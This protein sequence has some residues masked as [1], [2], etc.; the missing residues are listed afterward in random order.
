MSCTVVLLAMHDQETHRNRFVL[1]QHY[2]KVPIDWGMWVRGEGYATEPSSSGSGSGSGSSSSSDLGEGGNGSGRDENRPS[3][4]VG[5]ESGVGEGLGGGM[6]EREGDE[7]L[8]K[9]WYVSKPFEVVRVFDERE[10]DDNQMLERP[11][12]LVAVDFGHAVWIE[13]CDDEPLIPP[14]Q[15][16]QQHSHL[17]PQSLT[18]LPNHQLPLA[19]STGSTVGSGSGSTTINIEGGT[20]RPSGVVVAFHDGNDQDDNMT[21]GPGTDSM[22]TD[23]VPP[24]IITSFYDD[25]DQDQDQE[26]DLDAKVLKFVTFPGYEDGYE[27]E[28]V[29]EEVEVEEEDSVD[30]RENEYVWG[31]TKMKGKGKQRACDEDLDVDEGGGGGM[32]N[33]KD[34][35]KPDNTPYMNGSSWTYANG[36]THTKTM[37]PSSSPSTTKKKKTRRRKRRD[38]ETEGVVRTLEVPDELDLGNVE[39]INIDQSQGAVILSDREGKIFILCYE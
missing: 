20:G 38:R 12:P 23:V 17:P 24:P 29:E 14:P 21:V 30:S 9:M 10:D 8:M 31:N 35:S 22:T 39:T 11:R 2:F 18:M 33:G 26:Q 5:V 4:T 36:T 16:Q 3:D 34:K 27:E 15:H 6:E 19:S 13:Y 25:Q 37:S 7:D 32:A 1:A 28:W